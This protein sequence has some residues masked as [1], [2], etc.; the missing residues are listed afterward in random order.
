[1]SARRLPF[2]L[3]LA[4]LLLALLLAALWLAPGPAARWRAWHAPAPQPPN[5]DDAQ[6][7]LITADPAAAAEYPE[8]AD[9][10]LLLPARRPASDASDAASAAPQPI[11]QVTFT[12]IID[13]PTL[14]GVMLQDQDQATRFVRRGENVGDWTLQ[15]VEGRTITFTRR[16]ERKK[17]DLPY[18]NMADDSKDK[19]KDKG[20][21]PAGK[22]QP[23]ASP[24]PPAARS[25][26][27]PAARP[28]APA[29]AA[30]PASAPDSAAAPAA[31]PDSAA[32]PAPARRPAASSA[33]RTTS[34]GSTPRTTSSGSTP[35]T[36]SAGGSPRPDPAKGGTP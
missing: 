16:G 29:P 11:E 26:P 1:M 22:G 24:P 36:T 31:A 28:P 21:K 17:I 12:G 27:A 32:A 15:S 35:R 2:L 34:S 30:A 23:P 10:P 19:G 13:G 7:A 20:G 14:T 9:R 6:A 18:A 25:T 4:A 8:I 33:P 5:L 3:A